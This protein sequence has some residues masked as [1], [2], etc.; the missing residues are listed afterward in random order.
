M[1]FGKDQGNNS[2]CFRKDSWSILTQSHRCFI[3]RVTAIESYLLKILSLSKILVLYTSSSTE[4]ELKLSVL[5]VEEGDWSE[6]NWSDGADGEM[7]LLKQSLLALC[8]TRVSTST[9][10]IISRNF[11]FP[12]QIYLW[13]LINSQA[14]KGLEGTNSLSC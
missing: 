6:E 12:S 1:L 10:M 5:W 7:G 9:H 3:F 4:D 14:I 8:F 2:K 11:V 13:V